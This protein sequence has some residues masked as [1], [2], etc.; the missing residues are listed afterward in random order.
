VATL[1]KCVKPS[2]FSTEPYYSD[3][4]WKTQNILV[5]NNRFAFDPARIGSDCTPAKYCGFNGLFSEWGSLAPFQGTA[6][7]KHITFDQNNHFAS[8]SYYGPWQFVVQEQGN[9]VGW[10]MWRRGPYGQDAHSTM[11][12]SGG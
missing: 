5:E 3:C 10:S 8:N 6:V 2:L 4:R 12:G 11:H 7:E 9:V 1:G